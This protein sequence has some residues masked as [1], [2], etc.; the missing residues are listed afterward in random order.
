MCCKLTTRRDIICKLVIQKDIIKG[1]RRLNL[2]YDMILWMVEAELIC[3]I[4][5]Q[6]S[7]CLVLLG[8][9]CLVGDGI[10]R[11]VDFMTSILVWW[12]P[13]YSGED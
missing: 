8:F 3:I 6:I 10:K 1:D 12:D 9:L 2:R 5:I 4:L 7:L 11:R 13:E